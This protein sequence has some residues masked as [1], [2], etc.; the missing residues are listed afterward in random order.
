MKHSTIPT[1]GIELHVTEEG[2]GA[3]V[4]LCHGFPETS[5]S[6]RRQI[7]ALASAGY[8]VIAPDMRGYGGSSAP[9]DPALY[10]QLHI[11]G[12]LVGLLDSLGCETAAIVGHD[13]GAI[14]AWNA[15]LMRPDRFSRIAA[16]SVPY[17]PR[18]DISLLDQCRISAP[19]FYMLQFQHPAADLVLGLDVSA[20]LRSGYYA[21]S[22]SAPDADR[23]NPFA[24]PGTRAAPPPDPMPAWLDPDDLAHAIETFT[25][26][27]FRGGLNWYRAIDRTFELMA[28][29]KA[30]R[31]MQPSLF[32]AGARDA[33]LDFSRTFARDLPHN[34]PGLVRSVIVDGAGH[35]IQQ[36][37]P[38]AVNAALLDFLRGA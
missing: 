13:W 11:V 17:V 36:E 22:G 4:L 38:D 15:A 8:H 30:A 5:R 24:A 1:N 32:V 33:V 26:T 21:A 18:G 20:T 10:T 2:E 16:L 23:W 6:W 19:D 7:T 29:F 14:A 34:A 3:T 27:G 25:R 12:D 31:I 9:D 35:W 28:P 37:A